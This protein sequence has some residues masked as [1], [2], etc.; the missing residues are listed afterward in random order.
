V[1]AYGFT[2]ADGRDLFDGAA[3]PAPSGDGPGAWAAAPAGSP[4]RGRVRGHRASDLP[5]AIDDVLWVVELDGDVREEPR[6]VSAR[7]GRLV[8]RVVGWDHACA[9]AFVRDCAARAAARVAATPGDGDRVLAAGYLDDLRR[10][11]E[12]SYSPASAAGTAAYIG[13]RIAGIAAGP[14]GYEAG[15]DQ[16]R[17]AQAAW[18]AERLRL[19]ETPAG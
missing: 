19:A 13:A 1:L 5:F 7:R 8:S 4:L 10:Y 18:L 15:T 11:A 6:L 16:E 3:W 2:G 12:E 17:A 9:A 14:G